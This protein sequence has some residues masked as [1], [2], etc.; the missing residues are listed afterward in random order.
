MQPTWNPTPGQIALIEVA[1]ASDLCLTG[2]VT[3]VDGFSVTVDLGAS[4]TLPDGAA[5]VSFCVFQADALYRASA[6]AEKTGERTLKLEL[7]DIDRV[8]RRTTARTDLT[9]PIA[10]TAFDGP[11]DFI[12][13]VG[14][15]VDI[16][17]GGCRVRTSHSF[18]EGCNPTVTIQLDEGHTLIIGATVMDAHQR[19]GGWE[20]RLTFN[21]MD[22]PS[23]K[24]LD[25]LAH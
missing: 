5:N 19:P 12:S 7:D 2:V 18:P 25:D 16:G 23:A 11:S 15:T 21:E 6:R 24:L 10:L 9:M 1:D 8:Q 14:T 13:V 4:P 20:Y 17:P 22:E 3:E